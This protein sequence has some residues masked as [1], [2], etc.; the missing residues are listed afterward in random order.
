MEAEGSGVRL[1]LH[2]TYPTLPITPQDVKRVLPVAEASGFSNDQTP[3]GKSSWAA[4]ILVGE[5]G[6]FCLLVDQLDES[7][8]THP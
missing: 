3:Q 7:R 6:F 8:E 4:A 1:K 5:E 2:P